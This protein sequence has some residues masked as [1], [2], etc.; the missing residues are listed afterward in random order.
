MQVQAKLTIESII[1]KSSL[2]KLVPILSIGV[3]TLEIACKIA[4]NV[5]TFVK[6]YLAKEALLTSPLSIA[7]S[8]LMRKLYNL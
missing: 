1:A 8:K 6:A 2:L 5:Q 3:L 4:P 7:R